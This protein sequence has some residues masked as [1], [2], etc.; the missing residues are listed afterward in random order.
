[1]LSGLK[2]N[3]IILMQDPYINKNGYIPDVPK[4]HKQQMVT[5]NRNEIRRS[6]ILII[7]IYCINIKQMK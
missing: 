2:N 1:M 3:D 4:S 7:F 5:N 6:A